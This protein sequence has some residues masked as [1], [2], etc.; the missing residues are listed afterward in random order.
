MDHGHAGAPSAGATAK[1]ATRYYL[2]RMG[3][4]WFNVVNRSDDTERREI[5]VNRYAVRA[6]NRPKAHKCA[7]A[8]CN[9]TTMGKFC[10]LACTAKDA[11]TYD[12]PD[13]GAR[14]SYP[15][16]LEQHRM[17]GCYVC[18]MCGAQTGNANGLSHHQ[19]YECP[20]NV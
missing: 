13:C 16:A 11:A 1:I 2:L 8:L 9:A 19:A 3:R 10:S 5:E 4:I 17:R 12:C 6:M 7:Y 14:C 18:V 20:A 15:R